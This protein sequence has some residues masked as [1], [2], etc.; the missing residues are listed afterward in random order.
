M[1]A[2]GWHEIVMSTVG[3]DEICF[4]VHFYLDIGVVATLW[5]ENMV[6]SQIVVCKQSPRVRLDLAALGF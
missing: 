3:W 5:E 6:L 1:S 2:V 4:L